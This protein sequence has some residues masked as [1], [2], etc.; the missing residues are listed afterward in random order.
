M[1]A[2]MRETMAQDLHLL[3]MGIVLDGLDSPLNKFFKISKIIKIEVQI[4]EL[5]CFNFV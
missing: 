5:W 3:I 4:Y 2:N 1:S